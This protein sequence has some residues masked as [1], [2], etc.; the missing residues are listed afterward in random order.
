MPKRK[1][2]HNLSR[3]IPL[4][5]RRQIR[6]E[7]YFGCVVC[8]R[9]PYTYEHFDPPFEDAK[10]HKAEGM[11]LLCANCQA[12]TTAGR[13]S[14]ERI[15]DKKKKPFNA[16]RDPIW[17]SCLGGQSFSLR[18]AGN[19][20]HNCIKTQVVVNDEVLIGLELIDGELLLSGAFCD[21]NGKATLKLRELEIIANHESWDVEMQGM[22]LVIRSGVRQPVL[23]V[24]F[25]ATSRMVS[26]NR[27]RMSFVDGYEIDGNASSLTINTP[28]AK[29]LHFGQNHVHGTHCKLLDISFPG[30]GGW[31][32]WTGDRVVSDTTEKYNVS[33]CTTV[34]AGFIYNSSFSLPLDTEVKKATKSDLNSPNA[35]SNCW[36]HVW[37]LPRIDLSE[38]RPRSFKNCVILGPAIVVATG[39][40]TFSHCTMA[41]DS[42]WSKEGP[43]WGA[44]FVRDPVFHNCVFAYVGFGGPPEAMNRVTSDFMQ[45]SELLG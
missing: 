3:Y 16:S 42:V 37:E 29:D 32:N 17:M 8:G 11:T 38:I 25:D 15:A 4:P 41:L 26:V 28:F 31:D 44:F 13:L 12:D 10:E 43:L 14:K 9:L 2:K 33:A 27:L 34:G 24:A 5:L 39:N 7:S 23:E 18:F 22:N 6:Q 36:F 21:L 20:A 30:I 35:I 45:S 1:Q 40:A 19:T